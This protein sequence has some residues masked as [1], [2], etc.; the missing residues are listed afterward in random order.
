ALQREIPA[1]ATTLASDIAASTK[2]SVAVVDFTDLQG[3]V[4]ELGRFVAE[5]LELGLVTAKKS[6]SLVDRTHLR[7]ILQENKLSSSGLIDPATA[8]KLG[9]IT[10]VEA[11]VTGTITPF[12]DS[13]RLVIK[14]LDTETARILAA[15]STDIA[16]TRTIEEL[17]ARD[18]RRSDNPVTGPQP[19][20][21]RPVQANLNNPVFQ[22][23]PIRVTV[24]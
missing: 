10:G 15:S 12:G 19:S 8:R 24:V 9:Q 4:T 6:F 7:V 11:L 20:G 21:L 3:N 23:G 14:V 1:V 2:R 13:M 18:V 17:Q 16:K 5:E 22:S